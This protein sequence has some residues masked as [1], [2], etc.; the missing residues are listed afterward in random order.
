MKSKGTGTSKLQE[1]QQLPLSALLSINSGLLLYIMDAELSE[2]EFSEGAISLTGVETRDAS[3]FQSYLDHDSR[4]EYLRALKH[5]LNNKEAY[6]VQYKLNRADG[7]SVWIKDQGKVIIG[8]DQQ[9]LGITAT[10]TDMTS[11]RLLEEDFKT[12]LELAKFPM[13]NP[14]PVLRVDES[15]RLVFAN[16]S[17]DSLLQFLGLSKGIIYHDKLLTSVRS[18]ITTK[19]ST[20]IELPVSDTKTLLVNIVPS[21]SEKYVNIY[22]SDI[23]EIA[24]LENQ[25]RQHV[26]DL[27]AAL[28]SVDEKMILLDENMSVL[29]FNKM[30]LEGVK[31]F[32]GKS[33]KVGGNA[34]NYLDENLFS[35][36]EERFY[37]TLSAGEATTFE[38]DYQPSPK[39]KF[40]FRVML[41]PVRDE[42]N[43]MVKGI[44]ISAKNITDTKNELEQLEGLK[45]FYESILDNIPAD[46]AIFDDQHRY[47]YVN[48]QGIKDPNLRSW[49]IGKS[50]Y[51]YCKFRGIGT[52][53]ADERRQLFQRVLN[54]KKEEQIESEHVL[55]NGEIKYIIRKFFPYYQDDE[56]K[57]MIGY[58]VDFT[59]TKKLYK[60]MVQS[61]YRYR[62]LFENNPLL[63]IILD[64]AGNAISVNNTV[65]TETGYDDKMIIDRPL[66]N[67]MPEINRDAMNNRINACFNAPDDE[68]SWET[69]LNHQSG[70]LVDVEIR[71][72]VITSETGTPQL[73]LVCNNISSRK[74]N[75]R[76]L[77]ESEKLNRR[78]LQE[79]PLPVGIIQ[80]KSVILANEA[81][82]DLIE[83]PDQNNTTPFIEYVI[84]EDK[85][86]LRNATERLLKGNDN[87]D[88]TVRIAPQPGKIKHVFVRDSL[89]NYK[90][91]LVTLTVM[92]DISERVKTEQKNKE[93]EERTRLII[94]SSLDGVVIT[95]LYGRIIE[96]NKQSQSIFGYTAEE[97]IG[98]KLS[99]LIVPLNKRAQST[100][101]FT[102]NQL[103][104]TIGMNSTG[105]EFPIELF[106]AQIQTADN[107]LFSF[108]IRD[109][110]ARKLAERKLQ[111][112]ERVEKILNNYSAEAY[113]SETIPAVLET[114]VATFHSICNLCKITVYLV[115]TSGESL[116]RFMSDLPFQEGD[117]K[118]L[119][120][121]GSGLIGKAAQ[122][123]II[124]M[125]AD[126]SK[127]TIYN[128]E[129][130]STGSELAA[131][132][133]INNAT[134]AVLH[135]QTHIVDFFS[136]GNLV[137]IRKLLEIASGRISKIIDEQSQ[138][139]M[140]RELIRNNAQL[141][142]YSYIVSHN[143]RAPIANLLGLSR[144]FNLTNPSDDRNKLVLK[145]IEASAM[146]IDTILK[147]LNEILS[148]KKDLSKSKEYVD[149]SDVINT[150]L[151]GLEQDIKAAD[152]E[153]TIDLQVPGIQSIKS[154]ITSIFANLISNS[155]KYRATDRKCK[156]SIRS[157]VTQSACVLE[158]EDN[159]IGIDL[160]RHSDKIF[161]LYKRFHLHVDGTGIGLHLVKSQVE[162]LNGHV[163]IT[164][165][166]NEGTKFTIELYYE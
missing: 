59:E 34:E 33:L 48:P 38:F 101:I 132:I 82:R 21:T 40:W 166:V 96:W 106:T 15:G 10:L 154:Y 29:A 69:R 115:D 144:I 65:Q 6:S 63:V 52:A 126:R 67:I 111:E 7:T 51:D 162:A 142:Q 79:L 116:F 83:N 71:A 81:F 50:D 130:G 4:K 28:N 20:R 91:Q 93:I 148:I 39:K 5:A 53:I 35:A 128:I 78:L 139:K 113:R 3:V 32:L 77:E 149:F 19:S 151:K 124:F 47:V 72:K 66:I 136:E 150:A 121:F 131:P 1:L 152:P 57:L 89:F 127:D 94:D 17:A 12:T 158:F 88:Y 73:L 64:K 156:I 84:E 11:Q 104:E 68:F 26:M 102:I 95:D 30:A 13:E 146:N 22:V 86:M 122:E 43:D 85:H 18:A 62:T 125:I 42:V 98:K 60:S 160:E 123:N 49:M 135:Y 58:G 97:S 141:Q 117:Y 133:L 159:G 37:K 2:I 119:V 16:Q 114:L 163:A 138:L 137:I 90:N 41:N 147:D 25:L 118:N 153:L 103:I 56:F 44:C 164:S 75:E 99:D 8:K 92:N 36:F 55:A 45:S 31:R 87:V 46:I 143:L 80:D 9:I 110:S 129:K 140:N 155:I 23:S 134:Y 14:N 157:R 54:S 100:S 120:S 105:Q 107:R 61:E 74:Q 27:N 108:Y 24:T 70:K 145:N 76:L 165:T 161:G 112:S 109:I